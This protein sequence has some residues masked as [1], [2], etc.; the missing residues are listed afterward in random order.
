MPNEHAEPNEIEVRECTTIDEFEAC[1]RMQREV[2]GLPDVDIAPRPYLVVL[3][4]AGGWT[5]G[6]FDGSR[7]VGFVILMVAARNG[8][9]LIGY[10]HKMAVTPAY[11]NRGLG[12]RLKW[13]QRERA[14]L[15]GKSYIT[16]TWEPMGARNAHFNLNLLGATVRSYGVNF[17]GTNYGIPPEQAAR[18]PGIDSD[19]LFAE[20]D[21]NSARVRELAM[22]RSSVEVAAPAR[23]IEIPP[24]WR[25]LLQSDGEA[26]RREQLRVREEFLSAFD[27][28]LV[29]AAFRRDAARPRYLLYES[30]T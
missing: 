7:L 3:R 8:R 10:S 28:G 18:G 5:L 11:Q 19:R 20:W 16:W 17:Y 22:G 24:D 30:Q 15:E 23:T 13:A 6:A 27:A 14:L 12:A 4:R 2:F 26:A 21:L 1:V 9:E 25:A 29:C